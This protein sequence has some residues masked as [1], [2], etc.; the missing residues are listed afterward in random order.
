[1][2]QQN[3]HIGETA[4]HV[5]KAAQDANDQ[6]QRSTIAVRGSLSAI[7]ELGGDSNRGQPS[8]FI[9][10]RDFRSCQGVRSEHR[11]DR[12]PNAPACVERDN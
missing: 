2:Q 1:L 6:I 11:S 7:S 12:K 9:F 5:N 10:R 4:E 8:H 3:T